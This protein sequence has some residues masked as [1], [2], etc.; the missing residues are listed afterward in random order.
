MMIAKVLA[1]AACTIMISLSTPAAVAEAIACA[2]KRDKIVGGSIANPVNWPGLVAL[3]AYAPG[4]RLAL[5]TCGGTLIND[6]W[7]LTAAHCLHSNMTDLTARVTSSSGA[8][9]DG[10]LELVVETAD[11]A[12]VV[13]ARS[14]PARRVVIHEVYRAEAERALSIADHKRRAEALD[15]IARTTGHDIA[16]VELERPWPGRTMALALEGASDPTTRA[17]IPVRTA[18]FGLTE[19]NKV[20]GRLERFLPEGG[21]ESLAGSSRLRETAILTEE[22]GR[23][24]GQYLGAALGPAQICAGSELAPRDS[25]QGDSG[26]PLVV[27]GLD[28]CPLQVGIVSWGEGCADRDAKGKL[29]WGIYTRVSRFADW[30]ERHAGSLRRRSKASPELISGRLS[31]GDVEAALEQLSTLLGP[32]AMR[33][34]K[35][36]SQRGGRLQLG[37]LLAFDVTARVP[38]QLAMIDIDAERRVSLVYP[39]ADLAPA[40]TGIVRAGVQTTIPKPGGRLVMR[41]AEPIGRAHLLVLVLPSDFDIGRFLAEPGEITKGIVARPDPS[42]YLMRLIQQIEF[43]VTASGNAGS[44]GA[45]QWGFTVLDYEIV[46]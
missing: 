1:G 3:R 28:G 18:G 42:S 41:A 17:G 45:A 35:V 36:V 15:L 22:T 43:A 16:L 7:V 13:P 4:A 6:R 11:L 19:A 29:N 24:R 9:H 5:Y 33:N 37:T 2:A 32:Q 26:G 23:C 34:V 20:S 10:R 39:H 30:I 8:I 12:R 44:T 40:E 38:G 31:A 21:G 25:C 14:I 46:P 27:A